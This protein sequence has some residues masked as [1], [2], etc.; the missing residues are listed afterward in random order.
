MEHIETPSQSNTTIPLIGS[1]RRFEEAG[2]AYEII[3]LVDDENILIKVLE[4]GEE[5]T[6]PVKQA[7]ND[8]VA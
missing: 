5:L 6:Y 8:P 2:I 4:T 3:G 1:F 7:M